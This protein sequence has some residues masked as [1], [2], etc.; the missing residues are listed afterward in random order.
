[1][2]S[3]DSG[4]PPELQ[5]SARP[6]VR[7]NELP[8]LLGTLSLSHGM[9]TLSKETRMDAN[10]EALAILISRCATTQ[11]RLKRIQHE[12]DAL[13]R[14]QEGL[15]AQIGDLRRSMAFLGLSETHLARLE[16]YSELGEEYALRVFLDDPTREPKLLASGAYC[17]NNLTSTVWNSTGE[18]GV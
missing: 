16:D 5:K 12:R 17:C 8:V 6:R 3:P 2:A 13:N 9:M 4:Q 11:G 15:E 1:M 7:P 10:R 14:E 18:S